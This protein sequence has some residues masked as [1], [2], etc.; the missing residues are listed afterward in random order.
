MGDLTISARDISPPIATFRHLDQQLLERLEVAPREQALV[1]NRKNERA[2]CANYQGSGQENQGQG[3]ATG[4]QRSLRQ[5]RRID[6]VDLN[7]VPTGL[8]AG[9]NVS[10]K[11]LAL[12]LVLPLAC[13]RD[14]AR[15]LQ[16][17]G[18]ELHQVL[19]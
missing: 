18:F 12:D 5:E 3:G 15:E 2:Q 8:G 6:H 14:G 10:P 16:P 7:S 9:L 4:R 17:L 1:E 19:G 11:Q 13:L